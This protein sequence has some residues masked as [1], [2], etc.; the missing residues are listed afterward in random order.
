MPSKKAKATAKETSPRISL[1]LTSTMV[2]M[3]RIASIRRVSLMKREI[4]LSNSEHPNVELK[5]RITQDT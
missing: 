5:V 3:R 4:F 2:N 1:F